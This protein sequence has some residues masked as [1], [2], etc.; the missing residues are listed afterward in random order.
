M[1]MEMISKFMQWIGLKEKI[2]FS[3]HKPSRVQ[4]R[5]LWW[6][7]F[8]QNIGSEINGKSSLFSRPGIIIKRIT[9]A[10]YLVAPTTSKPKFGNWYAEISV[11]K[12]KTYA[13]LHQIRTID[14]RR[15]SNKIG[16]IDTAEF[17][18]IKDKFYQLYK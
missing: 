8:G 10:F 15:L 7:S 6:I 3:D 12:K 2:D 4:E 11:N 18:L 9:N 17:K 1:H 5:D 13:C 16:Q 14:H